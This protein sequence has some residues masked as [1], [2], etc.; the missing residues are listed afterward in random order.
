MRKSIRKIL[1]TAVTGMALMLAVGCGSSSEDTKSSS[2][3]KKQEDTN[4]TSSNDNEQEDVND[5]PEVLEM[6]ITFVNNT[7]IDIY[8]LYASTSDTDDWEEDLLGDNVMEPG[9]YAEINFMYTEDETVWDVAIEDDEENVLEF[10]DLNLED[11]DEQDGVTIYL[12]NDGTADIYEG[13]D[14]YQSSLQ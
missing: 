14:E 7:E 11:Y 3:D 6:P 9:D 12:N 1:L 13:A 4:A 8:C 5:E 2:N 10:Y